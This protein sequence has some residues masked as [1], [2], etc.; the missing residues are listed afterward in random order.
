MQF[1]ILLTL[2]FVDF[3]E[4]RHPLITSRTFLKFHSAAWMYTRC[5]NFKWITISF[6]FFL[7]S[8]WYFDRVWLTLILS[9]QCM[10]LQKFE[11]T[12][13]SLKWLEIHKILEALTVGWA[14]IEVRQH[15]SL[16]I[17]LSFWSIYIIDKSRLIYYV[18]RRCQATYTYNFSWATT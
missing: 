14:K 16:S 18:L 17:D 7:I 10:T 11:I 3:I 1:Q 8:G 5:S 15:D 9:V 6:E 12:C 2:L 4:N 13:S